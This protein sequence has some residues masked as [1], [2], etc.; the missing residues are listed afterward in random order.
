MK[1]ICIINSPRFVLNR[2][3]TFISAVFVLAV[4]CRS[5]SAD[6]KAPVTLDQKSPWYADVVRAVQPKYPKEAR[7]RR[8]RGSGVFRLFLD[9]KTGR[10]MRVEVIHSA[11]SRILD[12]SA[13]D[14]L[15]QWQ[16]KPG[17]WK[18]IDVP[19]TFILSGT[20]SPDAE[21]TSSPVPRLDCDS[22]KGTL[23]KN[24]WRL[25]LG[26]IRVSAHSQQRS[27]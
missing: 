8:L 20:Q 12:A 3:L 6:Q 18:Q 25:T 16:L 15:R 14:A 17:K 1:G 26:L 4:G 24:F 21:N 13:A 9:E 5:S 7:W 19:V 23:R 11:G 10:V 2:V 27:D 22:R